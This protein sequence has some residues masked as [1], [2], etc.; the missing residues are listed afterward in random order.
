MS[1]KRLIDA[2]KRIGYHD[3]SLSA[4][5]VDWLF[6]NECMLPFLEWFCDNLSS[7]NVLTAD[8]VKWYEF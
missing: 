4:E 8:E 3:E 1:G 5:S 6:E 7:L 2:L